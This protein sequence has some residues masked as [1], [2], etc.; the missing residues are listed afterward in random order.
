MPYYSRS[1]LYLV[2][3]AFEETALTPLAGMQL[4]RNQLV[5]SPRLAIDY[6]SGGA[7]KSESHG[8]FDNDAAT[9]STIM[10][11]ILGKKLDDAPRPDELVGY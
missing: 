3:R 7:T 5:K 11:R 9:L 8:S 10:K 1:L 4:H 6:A 2:S